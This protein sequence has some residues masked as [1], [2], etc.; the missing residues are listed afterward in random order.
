MRTLWLTLPLCLCLRAAPQVVRLED[1]DLTRASTAPPPMGYAPQFKKSVSGSPLTMHGVVYQDGA[2]MHSESKLLIDLHGSARRFRALAAI[3]DAPPALPAPLPGA[4]LPAGLRNHPGL[5]RV[6]MWPDGRLAYESGVQRRSAAPLPISVELTAI[7][8][9][10][11]ILTDTGRWPFNNPI[12]FADAVFELAPGGALPETESI[13]RAAVPKIGAGEIRAP[14]VHG[15]RV[16]AAS[17]GKPFLWRIPATGEGTVSF[18]AKNLSRGL[19][20]DAQTGVI[21]GTIAATGTTA[22]HLEVSSRFE[23]DS[24]D[25]SIVAGAGKLALTPPMGWNS[26]NIWARV[27][28]QAKIERA[29]DWLVRSGLAAHGYQY[30]SID[31]ARMGQRNAQGEI[32]AGANFPC[33]PRLAASFHF[34]GLKLGIYSSPG[35]KTCQQMEGG[36]GH[37][38]QDALT[39]AAWGIDFLKYDLCSYS[40]LVAGNDREQNEK[41]SRIMGEALRALPRDIVFSLCQ[42]G[43]ADVGEWAPAV[44]GQLWRT[45]GDIRDSWESRSTIGFAQ[46]RFAKWAEA[47]GWNDPYMLVVGILG[48]GVEPHTS[49]LTPNEE[50]THITLWSML[51]APLLLGCDLSRL[52]PFTLALLTDDEVL[53]VDQDP[54]GQSATRRW[55]QDQLEVWSRPLADGG[56]AVALFNRGVRDGEIAAKWSDLGISVERTVRDLWKR[57]AL[58]RFNRSVGAK[59]RAHGAVML[60]IGGAK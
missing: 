34:L 41:P 55:Q 2:G 8:S 10:L 7:R 57:R 52:D 47:G 50:M 53:D 4:A 13:P 30:I 39:Y 6:Q 17:R 37:E 11:L 22:V 16:I 51:A 58:G 3:D 60:K 28:D 59:V 36:L 31:D 15:P 43:R 5:G 21:T 42:Y 46:D 44:G 12:D 54:L 38:R 35:P 19:S 33:V 20:V 48:W 40:A 18:H 29:A 49:R 56:I 24:R 23:R 14:R 25:V 27:V 9:M 1:L 26:W 45:T 32:Q